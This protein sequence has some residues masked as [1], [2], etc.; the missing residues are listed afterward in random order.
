MS[1]TSPRRSGF[2]AFREADIAE[3][4]IVEMSRV[5]GMAMANIAE[6]TREVLGR[7]VIHPGDDERAVALRF[8]MS[9]RSSARKSRT[10]SS[11]SSTASSATRSAAT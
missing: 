2:V 7:T 10:S 9:A 1:T 5:M 6:G 3:D 11:T 4:D 8:A